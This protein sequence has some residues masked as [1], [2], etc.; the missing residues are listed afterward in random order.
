MTGA[1]AFN[2]FPEGK[3]A[4]GPH[5]RHMS[6]HGRGEGPRGFGPGGPGGPFGFGG[7]SRHRRRMRRGDV[8]AAVLVLLAEAAN[9]GYGLMQEIENRSDGVWRPSPG[10]MYPVLAQLEDEALISAE[11]TEGRK[12]YSLT[13]AGTAY[14]EENREKLGEPW[15]GLGDEVG[16]GRLELHSLL[17]QLAMAMTQVA[18][19]GT[20]AQI[21]SARKILIDA[22]KGLYRLLASDEDDE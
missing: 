1:Y 16:E 9:N 7:P 3:C 11:E 13:E 18:S 5:M 10:S 22:R 12:Q 17:R 21:E 2:Y 20:D 4:R 14:V 19:A 15:A 8:R 6:R